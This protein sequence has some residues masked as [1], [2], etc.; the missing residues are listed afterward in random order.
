MRRVSSLPLLCLGLTLSVALLAST[1]CGPSCRRVAELRRTFR[2][3]PTVDADHG[4]LLIPLALAND[5][6]GRAASKLPPHPLELPGLDQLTPTLGKLELRVERAELVPVEK[7]RLGLALVLALSSKAG[8]LLTLRAKT[9]LTPR[10]DKRPDGGQQLSFGLDAES[11]RT[12]RPELAPGAARDLA[13]RLHPRL[14]GLLRAVLSVDKLAGLLTHGLAG[15]VERAYGWLRGPL[16]RRLGQQRVAIAL[17]P[18]PLANAIPRTVAKPLPQL[19]IGLRFALPVRTGLPA[20][21]SPLELRAQEPQLRLS[22]SAVAELGNWAMA[23]GLVPKRYDQKFRPTQ[24]G[25]V[26]PILDWIAGDG[27]PLKVHVFRRVK[28]CA[29]VR[30]GARA[31]ADVVGDKLRLRIA[32]RRVEAVDGPPIVKLGLF[33]DSLWSNNV[34][35]TQERAAAISFER[36]GRRFNLRLSRARLRSDELALGFSIQVVP[37]LAQAAR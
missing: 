34:A 18:L 6:L 9:A 17:P 14:P 23:Q 2:E 25:G 4:R 10:F 11:L 27:R 1:G 29:H 33:F 30:V 7:G 8:Q 22:G 20:A 13:K 26:E 36:G 3:R 21:T 5:W 31:S 37:A 12:L 24:R 15:L 19:E 32:D 35:R 16:G 28:P